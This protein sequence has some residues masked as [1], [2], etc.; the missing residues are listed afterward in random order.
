MNVLLL[1]TAF[2]AIPIYTYLVEA[3]HDVWVMG[4]RP[5]DPLAAKAGTNWVEQDYSQI[6]QV[7]EHIRRL[8]IDYVVPGCT[9]VSI[10]SCLKLGMNP[11]LIDSPETNALLANK[12]SFRRLCADVGLPAP[13]TFRENEFPRR[14]RFICKPVDAFSGRGVTVCNGEDN[15]ALG[16]AVEIAKRESPTNDVLIET[17][18]EGDLYSCSAFIE[19]RQLTNVFYVRE[20]ASVNPYAVDTSYVVH[21]IDPECMLVL[22]DSLQ[23]LCAALQ[24]KDGLLHTQFILAGTTPYIVEVT[25]RCPGDLYP[26][27]IEYSTGFPYAAKYAAYFVGARLE[28]YPG[29]TRYVLRHT[30]TSLEHALFGGL[31]F[32]E[33]KTVRAFFPILPMGQA[34]LPLQQ[35]RAGLLFTVAESSEQMAEDYAGFISRSSYDVGW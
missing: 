30:V 32:K 11:H 9:D 10:D 22:Q 24:L 2:A 31:R 1:D 25:R 15:E 14:G 34:L 20:G 13:R 8:G 4:N 21:D 18:V 17:F 29:T 27:L 5:L 12:A 3:G 33:P 16:S 35:N 23:R 19:S 28:A 26:L 6:R 7:S